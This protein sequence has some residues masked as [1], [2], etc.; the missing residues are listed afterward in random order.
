MKSIVS[1]PLL[2]FTLG[3]NAEG[4]MQQINMQASDF[5]TFYVDSTIEGAG[6][7]SLLVDTGSGYTTINEDT[8]TQLQ[9]TGTA[10]YLKK[11]EGVMADGTRMIVSVYRISGISLGKDC[12]IP[13]IEVAVFPSGTRQILGLS[14]LTKISPFTFSMNPPRLSVSNC[15]SV[16]LPQKELAR[17]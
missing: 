16:N 1:I 11:L 9:E 13:N 7:T 17:L 8:L 12:Y 6:K 5:N 14:A 4:G 3:V 15:V 2:V 10:V